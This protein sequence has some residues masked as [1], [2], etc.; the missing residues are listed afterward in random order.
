MFDTWFKD[1]PKN[2]VDLLLWARDSRYTY[3]DICSAVRVARMKGIS[4]ISFETLRSTLTDCT[5]MVEVIKMPWS[6]DIEK[7]SEQNFAALS[8]LFNHTSIPN[9]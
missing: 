5:K 1:K 9:S 2:F 8:R 6:K 7:G 4:D 3:Q